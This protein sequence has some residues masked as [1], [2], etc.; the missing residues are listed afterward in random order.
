MKKEVNSLLKKTAKI[1]GVTCVATGAI[2]IMTSKAALQVIGKGCEYFANSV[3]NII[4][5]PSE[6][7]VIEAEPVPVEAEAEG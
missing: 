3:K 2:A 5:D 4:N 1:A 7:E 6:P